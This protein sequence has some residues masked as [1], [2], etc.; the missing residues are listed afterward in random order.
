MNR[1]EIRERIEE[2]EA[3]AVGVEQRNEEPR[4]QI[5]VLQKAIDEMG[6][7]KNDAEHELVELQARL[8]EVLAGSFLG[9]NEGLDL[10]G[11]KILECEKLL[12]L[13]F[14]EAIQDIQRRITPFRGQIGATA[15]EAHKTQ[16]E[17]SLLQ[18][19]LIVRQRI[20]AGVDRTRISTT[21]LKD[22]NEATRIKIW[23]MAA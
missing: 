20:D 22:R 19:A 7:I 1:Q 13:P 11:N 15:S 16:Q 17:I 8:P 3:Q 23:R 12:S 6:A 2:L 21:I 4:K 10:I 18:A 9:E 5:A 14:D